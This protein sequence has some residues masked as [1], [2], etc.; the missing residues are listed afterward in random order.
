M[1]M[2][3]KWRK[4]RVPPIPAFALPIQYVI[5]VAYVIEQQRLC[6]AG[7]LIMAI[8]NALIFKHVEQVALA[9]IV[10]LRRVAHFEGLGLHVIGV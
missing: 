10:K 3:P 5:I 6:T 2:T 7:S 8:K 4:E 9:H 1:M